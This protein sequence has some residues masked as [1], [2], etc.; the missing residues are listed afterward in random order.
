VDPS[1]GLLL[2]PT[3]I[4]PT[5]QT[6]ELDS[7]LTSVLSPSHHTLPRSR[8]SPS[9][10]SRHTSSQNHIGASEDSSLTDLPHYS[11]HRASNFDSRGQLSYGDLSKEIGPRTRHKT[12][13]S[14]SFEPQLH[15]TAVGTTSLRHG[16][17]P[18]AARVHY[19]DTVLYLG[20]QP[21]KR[22]SSHDLGGQ[23]G[24]RVSSHDL[25]RQPEKSSPTRHSTSR[26]SSHDR[27]RSIQT[28]LPSG[29]SSFSSNDFKY[30]RQ[31][32]SWQ[33]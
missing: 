28:N 14:R 9:H 4:P 5:D 16:R 20:G 19:G 7:L 23:P 25:G 10:Y 26:V 30:T 13:T 17:A 21:G 27:G 8:G 2:M 3:Q 6:N 12:E 15:S 11:E 18:G 1:T 32:T 22:V 29:T 33:Q 31:P 24:K